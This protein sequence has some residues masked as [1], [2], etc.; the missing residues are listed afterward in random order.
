MTSRLSRRDAAVKTAL[1]AVRERCD[2]LA[3]REAYP[4]GFAHRYADEHDQEL[5][6]LGGRYAEMYAAC[7]EHL[8][9]HDDATDHA[10]DDTEPKSGQM[11]AAPFTG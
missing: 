2:V 5:V 1:D 4:V 6:A 3:R 9:Q 10:C 7:T 11:V 8:T